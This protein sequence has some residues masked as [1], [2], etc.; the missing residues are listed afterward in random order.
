M[1]MRE[2][3]YSEAGPNA[4]SESPGQWFELVPGSSKSDLGNFVC[5]GG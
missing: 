2:L 1:L 5:S 4:I 3:G